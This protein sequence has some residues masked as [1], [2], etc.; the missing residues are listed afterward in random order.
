MSMDEN[1]AEKYY[2]LVVGCGRLGSLLAN[3]LSSAGHELVVIDRNESAFDALSVN[4]SGYKIVGDAS[5]Q[6]ILRQANIQDA[7]YV[8]AATSED[9]VNL[10][11]AQIA[12][13]IFDVQHVVARIDDVARE[14]IFGEFGIRTISP[15]RLTAQAFLQFVH[16]DVEE[17]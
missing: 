11:V 14:S 10:M 6:A 7:D 2:I 15:T 9:N 4:F 5:E 13:R 8:F 17:A 3:Q 1:V 16:E 12:N